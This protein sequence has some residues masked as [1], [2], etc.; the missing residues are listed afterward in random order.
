MPEVLEFTVVQPRASPYVQRNKSH[1]Q[2]G[3]TDKYDIKAS[4][5]SESVAI[6]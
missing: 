6:V 2:M 1:Q 4:E 5:I 3:Y